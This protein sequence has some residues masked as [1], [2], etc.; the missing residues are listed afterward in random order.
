MLAPQTAT[1]S[2]ISAQMAS[3]FTALQSGCEE[4]DTLSGQI[5]PFQHPGTLTEY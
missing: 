5:E 1:A 2:S 4:L 3:F